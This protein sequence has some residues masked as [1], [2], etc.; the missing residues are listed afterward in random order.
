MEGSVRLVGGRY[1]LEEPP[2]G[3]GQAD[4]YKAWDSHLSRWVAVKFPKAE[5][6]GLPREDANARLDRELALLARVKHP[7]VVECY[8][9]G[10]GRPPNGVADL[11]YIVLNFVDGETLR[12][13][14]TRQGRLSTDEALPIMSQVLRA[15]QAVHA[16]G[17]VHRDV[18]PAN[19]I[20]DEDGKVTLLDLG[21]AKS[22]QDWTLTHTGFGIG[23][24]AYSSPEQM[25]GT[26]E[27]DAR[28]DV[29][30]A[31]CLMYHLL[32]GQEPF[33]A[34]DP[35]NLLRQRRG[36]LVKPSV[37]ASDPTLE[38]YDGV[39]L[40]AISFDA[41]D[42]F[43]TAEAM[44][45]SLEHA[46]RQP[47]LDE[48]PISHGDAELPT[49]PLAADPTAQ[50]VPAVNAWNDNS[51]PSH[52]TQTL[53]RVSEVPTAHRDVAKRA[54]MAAVKAVDRPRVA[55]VESVSAHVR[56]LTRKAVVSGLSWGVAGGLGVGVVFVMAL[57]LASGA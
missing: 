52:Q 11:P 33:Q 50:T 1:Q 19:V 14:M 10:I 31:G 30:S 35:A 2:M 57:I 46:H 18:K 8:D 51:W 9:H 34:D 44:R 12:H 32:T 55:F 6:A 48:A 13:R 38:P 42:R 39:V 26:G 43:Q 56:G 24:W 40:K 47:Q 49:A 29:Y 41:A 25:Q 36:P 27:L 54:R 22:P 4:V 15:L 28:S 17:I 53:L 21:I 20:I 16:A 3:G 7:N 37:L 5:F 23:T 45:T